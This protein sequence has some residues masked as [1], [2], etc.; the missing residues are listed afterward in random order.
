MVAGAGQVMDL[1]LLASSSRS[2]LGPTLWRK[3]ISLERCCLMW[4]SWVSVLFKESFSF[5]PSEQREFLDRILRCAAGVLGEGTTNSLL[6]GSS[7]WT[8]TVTASLLRIEG[9]KELASGVLPEGTTFVHVHFESSVLDG[10]FRRTRTSL[11]LWIR[12]LITWNPS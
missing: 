12:G 3:S 1:W 11:T 10:Y 2:W 4:V 6:V 7:L 5:Y 8:S 9:E